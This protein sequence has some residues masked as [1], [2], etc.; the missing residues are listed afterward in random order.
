MT[1]III[2]P[3]VE[4]FIRALAPD[5]R[6]R[7]V[8]ALKSL[9][10]GDTKSLEGKLSGYR[11]LRVGGFRVIYADAMKKG[12][13]AFDCIFIERRPVVYDLFQQI[14]AEQALE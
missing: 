6:K 11:R 2:F 10:K 7:L 4:S 8:H 5:S 9:P 1:R 13:R 14:V 3:Q 12:V